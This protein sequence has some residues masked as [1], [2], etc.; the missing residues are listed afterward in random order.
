LIKSGSAGCG[1][2]KVKH[3]IQKGCFALI[4]AHAMILGNSDG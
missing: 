3:A 2:V 1:P 4:R